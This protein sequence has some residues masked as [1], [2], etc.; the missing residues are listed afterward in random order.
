M[1]KC[2]LPEEN[3]CAP[4]RTEFKTCDSTADLYVLYSERIQSY[5][6]NVQSKHNLYPEIR[7]EF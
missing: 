5:T 2:P 1:K 7:K 4:S 3:C 6:V